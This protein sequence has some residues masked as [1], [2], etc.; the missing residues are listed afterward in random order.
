MK[1]K[2]SFHLISAFLGMMLA[3][4]L[5]SCAGES[6]TYTGKQQDGVSYSFDNDK[7]EAIATGYY[8]EDGKVVTDIVLPEYVEAGKEQFKVV[9]I[10][11]RAF[12]GG[13]FVSLTLGGN[14]R[15][16]GN[17]AFADCND[18]RTVRLHG[19]RLPLLPENAFEQTVYDN[20]RLIVSSGVDVKGTGWE[21]FAN[22]SDK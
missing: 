18:I 14:V 7:S 21:K 8:V 11:D 2:N 4:V 17:Q 12:V 10:A 16:I 1:T 15:S 6:I 9:G 3:F 19:E 5:S 13:P 20:A 22:V